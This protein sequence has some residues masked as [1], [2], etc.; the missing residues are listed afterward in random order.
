MPF[1][2]SRA[3]RRL[4]GPLA[5]ISDYLDRYDVSRP[6]ADDRKQ[7][8]LAAVTALYY[9]LVTD[10]FEYGWGRSFHFAPG[11]PGERFKQSIAR[12][13]HYM[14]HVLG[15]RPGMVVADIGCGVGGP[16]LEIARFSGARIVGVN[17]NAHQIGKARRFA[18]EAQLS[19]LTDFLE[20]DFLNVDAPD[21][22]FDAAYSIEA[23]CHAPDKV[24]VY[25][26]IYRL[27]K[28]GAQFAVYEYCTTDRYDSSNPE[29]RSLKDDI[30]RGG[31]LP[32]IDDMPTVDAAFE[33]VGFQIL[34]SRDL[35]AQP[36]P[37][38]PWYQPLVGSGLSIASVR[39]SRLGR[40][41]T[42]SALRLLETLRIAPKGSVRTLATLELCARAMVGAG[43][44]GIFTPMYFVHVRKPG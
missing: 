35:A 11:V 16:L 1:R 44:L 40:L 3:L 32:N 34:E 37:S 9:D 28:P 17:N 33:T 15:L 24:S 38:I 22:S 6:T 20:C 31:G 43:R 27:L 4:P 2:L 13:E 26:E 21:E 42:I 8:E 19:Q 41:I 23:T 25:S 10:F 29:H 7:G 39:G 14:A 18:E 36:Y 30:E 12:H 5:R